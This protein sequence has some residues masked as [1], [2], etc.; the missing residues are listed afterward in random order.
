MEEKNDIRQ[1]QQ[2]AARVKPLESKLRELQ[3]QVRHYEQEVMDLKVS[4]GKE[5]S[6]IGKLEGFLMQA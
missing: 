5:C 2:E 1:L 6:D 4:Y 3:A